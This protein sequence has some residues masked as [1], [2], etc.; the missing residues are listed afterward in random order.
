MLPVII[1]ALVAIIIILL[2]SVRMVKERSSLVVERFGKYNRILMPGLNF[3]VPFLD[4][5]SRKMNLK[6]QQM[7]VHVETKTKDNVFI[8]LQAS[9]HVQFMANIS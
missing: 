9:F 5:V 8:K 1:G 7:N 3:L 6:I 4:K 2:S